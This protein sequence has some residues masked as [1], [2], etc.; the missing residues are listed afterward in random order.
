MQ[1]TQSLHESSINEAM[2]VFL[3]P[4]LKLLSVGGDLSSQ[5]N[6]GPKKWPKMPERVFAVFCSVETFLSEVCVSEVIVCVT[7]VK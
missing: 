4:F 2:S 7:N 5:L 3:M 1:R 6:F